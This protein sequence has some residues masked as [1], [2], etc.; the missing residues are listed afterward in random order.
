MKRTA[1]LSAIGVVACLGLARADE[2]TYRE[3]R[4][5]T[6]PPTSSSTTTQ[7][8]GDGSTRTMEQQTTIDPVTG[9]RVTRTTTT[10]TVQAI[11][12]GHS[13][14]L[15]SPDGRVT[16]YAITSSS[17]VPT[18]VVV[19]RH[20]TIESDPGTPTPTIRSMRFYESHDGDREKEKEEEH[21]HKH[22]HD[23]DD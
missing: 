20:V 2:T 16:S 5:V 23:D 9:Q 1:L 8:M 18:D 3:E 22:H 14:T 4:T 11:E 13:V 15:V 17:M 19:G 7:R 6:P 10:Y 21:H 12:P